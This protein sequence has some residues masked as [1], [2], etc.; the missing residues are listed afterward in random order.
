[1]FPFCF[2]ESLLTAIGWTSCLQEGAP[3]MP[4]PS[5][6]LTVATWFS[7]LAET[8]AGILKL[9]TLQELHP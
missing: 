6:R 7:T 2:A 5:L 8:L 4:C 9:K 3:T 1:M